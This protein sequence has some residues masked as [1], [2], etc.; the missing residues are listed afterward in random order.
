MPCRWCFELVT[1]RIPAVEALSEDDKQRCSSLKRFFQRLHDMTR[2][3]E[4]VIAF[5]D[6]IASIAYINDPKYHIWT[7]HVDILNPY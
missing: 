7:K 5:C 6:I 2:A 1:D 4:V 3:N